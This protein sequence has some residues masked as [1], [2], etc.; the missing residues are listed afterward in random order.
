MIAIGP[1]MNENE[2]DD[3][4][5][6]KDN[7]K[8]TMLLISLVICKLSSISFHFVLFI[9]ALLPSLLLLNYYIYLKSKRNHE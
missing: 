2:A 8:T 1:K 9:L 3:A 4:K 6:A 7:I 5:K